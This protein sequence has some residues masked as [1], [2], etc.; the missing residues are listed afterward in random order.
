MLLQ[1]QHTKTCVLPGTDCSKVQKLQATFLYYHIIY[2]SG[3]REVFWGCG[4]FWSLKF[5]PFILMF[6]GCGFALY[7]SY[8]N[9]YVGYVQGFWPCSFDLSWDWGWGW[10]D[11]GCR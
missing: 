7:L 1:Q 5:E 9:D 6:V 8:L 4:E 11:W 3:I 10:R 2:I